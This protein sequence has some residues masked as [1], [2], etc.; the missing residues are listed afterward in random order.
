VDKSFDLNGVDPNDSTYTMNGNVSMSERRT[1]ASTWRFS[2]STQSHGHTSGSGTAG[3]VAFAIYV[4][5]PHTRGGLERIQIS[6]TVTQSNAAITSKMPGAVRTS[7]SCHTDGTPG[8]TDL[9]LQVVGPIGTSGSLNGS[10]NSPRTNS[11]Q[12]NIGASGSGEGSGSVTLTIRLLG[13]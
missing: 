4:T 12:C 5:N 2:I 10:L 7:L 1:D 8:N 6:A 9:N 13:R 11:A 3:R